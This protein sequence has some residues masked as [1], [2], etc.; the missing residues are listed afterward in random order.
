MSKWLPPLN[1]R[2]AAEL[3]EVVVTVCRRFLELGA[4]KWH[5]GAYYRLINHCWRKRLPL[6]EDE[7]WAI[8]AAHGMPKKFEKE[9]RRAYLEGTEL[10]VYAHG[11][12]PIKKKRVSP[13]SLPTAMTP[14]AQSQT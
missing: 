4:G 10:L 1:L 5:R 12:K 14:I 9:A 3:D 13:L 8:L 11:R 6:S 2:E 7:V